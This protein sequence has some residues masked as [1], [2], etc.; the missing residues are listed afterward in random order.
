MDHRRSR[1]IPLTIHTSF[2]ATRISG[3]CLAEAYERLVPTTRRR[4]R[5]PL[6]A[7]PA[8]GMA[9]RTWRDEHA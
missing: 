6:E 4:P 2:E 9:L 7:R 5:S 3:R 1:P 8:E